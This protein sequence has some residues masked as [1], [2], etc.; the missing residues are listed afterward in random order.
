MR[1]VLQSAVD[2]RAAEIE[3][4]VH[5]RRVELFSRRRRKLLA[6]L[7]AGLPDVGS[8]ESEPFARAAALRDIS[9]LAASGTLALGPADGPQFI[10][11]PMLT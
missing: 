5:M 4:R 8:A 7:E 10:D 1:P 9:A 2:A 6:A 3:A 11:R